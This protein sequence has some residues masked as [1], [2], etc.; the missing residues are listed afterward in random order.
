MEKEKIA[1]IG[2]G[3]CGFAM[4]ADLTLAGYDVNL[5]EFPRFKRNIEIISKNGGIELTGVSRTGFAKLAKIS[6]NLKDVV[7]GTAHIMVSI[8]ALGHE[9]LANMLTPLIRPEQY[10]FIMPGNAGSFVFAKEFRDKGV[11]ATIAETITFPYGCRKTSEKSVNISRLL[12]GN[13]LAALPSKNLENSLKVFRKFYPDVL[14]LDNV[15]EAALYNPNIILHPAATILNM[16]RIEYAKGDFGLYQEGFS[17]SVMK[18]LD[19]LDRE[20]MQ[21]CEKLGMRVL[22][23][24]EIMEM[25]YKKSFDEHFYGVMRE[26]GSKGPFDVQTRYITEDVPT[27]MVLVSS[28][29]RWLN[30]PTPTFDAFI[31]LGGLMNDTDY[32]GNGL[33]VDKIGIAN[34]ALDELKYFLQEGYSI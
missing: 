15:L 4:A 21:I 14:K 31:Q 7:E 10:L 19:A 22:S 29:G 1:V 6:T 24:K 11:K 3:N 32:W 27:G 2:A 17:P 18:V 34:M 9:E 30:L 23:Y 33:T 16:A 8:Q 13:M 12:A 25:R 5:F 26:K 28:I 20:I